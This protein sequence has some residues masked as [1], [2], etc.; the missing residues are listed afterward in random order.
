M[1]ENKP[2]PSKKT[3]FH[4]TPLQNWKKIQKEGLLPKKGSRSRS[5]GEK[6]E[7][8]FLFPDL[9]TVTD[10]LMNWMGELFSERTKLALLKI[11]LP[12]SF[13]VEPTFEGPESWE[14]TTPQKIEPKYINFHSE[15]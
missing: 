7:Q 13:L 1:R 15:A 3:F 12:K 2:D 9:D 11:T 4:V 10:A 5:L 14:W 6:K 8:V